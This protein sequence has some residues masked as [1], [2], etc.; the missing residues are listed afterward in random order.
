M[1]CN[2][3]LGNHGT[4]VRGV[5]SQINIILHCSD[6]SQARKWLIEPLITVKL[7]SFPIIRSLRAILHCARVALMS[8]P[9]VCSY[10]ALWGPTQLCWRTHT[11]ACPCK[12]PILLF[13]GCVVCNL[14]CFISWSCDGS[15]AAVLGQC[16]TLH[17]LH[18]HI[19]VHSKTGLFSV[20][21]IM[22]GFPMNNV[23]VNLNPGS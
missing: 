20:A 4:F 3:T 16:S 2:Q 8:G 19:W 14:C 1:Y 13:R 5:Y 7:S 11:H 22:R 9:Q 18:S 17:K 21:I 10:R 12:W 23:S 6:C 15:K